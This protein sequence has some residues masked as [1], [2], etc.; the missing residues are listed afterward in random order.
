M[1]RNRIL[2]TLWGPIVNTGTALKLKY[3]GMFLQKFFFFMLY[4][5]LIFSKSD[6][7]LVSPY[8]ITLESNILV[9]RIKEMIRN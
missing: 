3:S 5:Y 2:I 1:R 4:M 9:I 7:V 6:K 8:N